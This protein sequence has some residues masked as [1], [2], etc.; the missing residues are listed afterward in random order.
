VITAVLLAAGESRRMGS[1]KAL[2]DWDHQTLIE[3]QIEQLRKGGCDQVVAVL[4][5][6]HRKIAP[7]AERAGAIAVVNPDHA[8]GRASSLRAGATAVPAGTSEVAVISV[9][10]PRPASVIARLLESHLATGALITV[11]TCDGRRGHPVFLCGSLVPEL[12]NVNET[13]KGLRE[14]IRRR[15]KDVHELPFDTDIVLLDINSPAD[16]DAAQKRFVIQ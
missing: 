2:L 15:A 14:I 7:L 9:D 12:R 11:P 10:Q 16:Y 5:H 4:G 6:A 13:T 3:Y 1:P 8:E